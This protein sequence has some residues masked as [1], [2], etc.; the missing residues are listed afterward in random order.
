MKMLWGNWGCSRWID[1]P[2]CIGR[3]VASHPMQSVSP[4]PKTWLI[5]RHPWGRCQATVGPKPHVFSLWLPPDG[6][7][8]PDSRPRS[9]HPPA[10][11]WQPKPPS[12]GFIFTLSLHVV[13]FIFLQMLASTSWTCAKV[14]W[15]PHSASLSNMEEKNP[16]H[17]KIQPQVWVCSLHMRWILLQCWT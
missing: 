17:S 5:C 13:G 12:S 8:G 10:N 11:S 7:S 2:F 4:C 16:D 14:W 3:G 1:K 6:C 15:A 9:C